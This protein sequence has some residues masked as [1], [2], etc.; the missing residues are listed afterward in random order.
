MKALAVVYIFIITIQL[1]HAQEYVNIWKVEANK[2]THQFCNLNGC[3]EKK[4]YEKEELLYSLNSR[5]KLE[6]NNRIKI[7][8]NTTNDKIYVDKI[9]KELIFYKKT[10]EELEKWIELGMRNNFKDKRLRTWLEAVRTG[11]PY[12]K[13]DLMK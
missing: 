7:I 4:T 12:L 9:K 1:S 10:K 13:K 2:I 8:N 3:D 11:I 6:R 5:F